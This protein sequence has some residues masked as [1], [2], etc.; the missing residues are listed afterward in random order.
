MSELI[1]GGNP[2][3][4]V[5]GMLFQRLDRAGNVLFEWSSWDNYHILDAIHE[6]LTA[7]SIKY[8]HINSV[9]VDYDGHYVI[10]SRNLSEVT[11]INSQTGEIIWRLGG[12]NNQFEFIN[13]EYGISYQH[14]VRPVPDKP[15]FYTIFDNGQFHTP[16][17]SRAV[18]YQVDTLN[19]TATKVWEYR[20]NPDRYTIFKGNAQRL[21]NGNTLINWV[22]PGLP[23]AT[24]VGP[25]GEI[26]YEM[27]FVDELETYRTFRFEWEGMLESPYLIVESYTDKVTLIFNKFGDPDVNSYIVY[28]GQDPETLTVIDTTG[29]TWLNLT[30]LENY[31][32]YH[33][34]VTA[35]TNEGE[36]S[37]YSNRESIF[38]K[39]V[40]PGEN[41]IINGDFSVDDEHWDLKISENASCTSEI[42]QGE[43]C[44]KIDDPGV[45]YEDIQ[46]MQ[47]GVQL[48]KGKQYSLEFDARADNNR[49]IEPKI[50]SGLNL[51]E[52]YSH[53]GYVYLT[54]ELKHYVFEIE[55]E[56]NTN[57]NAR[58]V[59][60]CGSSSEYVFIDNVSLKEVVA[61]DIQTDNDHLPE[62]FHL[63]DNF[64]NPFNP[65]TI[66][67][68]KLPITNDVDLSIY[69][70][71]GQKV[72]TLVSKKQKA[73]NY[74]VEWD[75]SG[76]ASGVYYYRLQTSTD[77]V[78]TKKLILLK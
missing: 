68:Y 14:D 70:L 71:L 75:A 7:A 33:F 76:Y 64:P 56:S 9:A 24:E 41:I 17:F 59:F 16:Q 58:L 74:K 40:D 23:E 13:D 72:V 10:S 2:E 11:K 3:A 69:N 18:E 29:K 6:N 21:P 27:D 55:M 43:Y 39:Y 73:G 49:L 32:F 77:F 78:Q 65:K 20:P 26:V 15:N 36:E 5:R 4:T 53:I 45:E 37:D 61:S 51:G 38:V 31:T 60:N 35:L 62:R 47:T 52:N 46:L 42:Y 50:E 66:I 57:L 63:F 48:I 19:M 34:Q 54:N 8:V 67:N 22:L 12:V 25:E 1:E 28:G 44:L 30:D